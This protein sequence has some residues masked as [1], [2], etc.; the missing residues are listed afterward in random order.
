MNMKL[1]HNLASLF[2]IPQSWRNWI[3]AHWKKWT[4]WKP[5]WYRLAKAWGLCN[6]NRDVKI[7]VSLTSYPGRIG[8]VHETI[9]TLLT[10][11]SK[12]DRVVLW[13]AESQF[14]NREKDLPR[15]LR[16]LEQYG[17]TIKWCA[18]L[19]SYKKL[20]PSLKEYPKDLIITA[21]DDQ[22][23][24]PVMIERLLESYAKNLKCIHTILSMK[25]IYSGCESFTPYN[26]WKYDD[27]FA[28]SFDNLL[29]G[30][31]GALYPPN[32]LDKEVFNED[33]FQ[34]IAPTVDDIWFWAMATKK[35]TRVCHVKGG[36][37]DMLVQN[38]RASMTDAL[39]NTNIDSGSGNDAQL[40]AIVKRYPELLK[41]FAP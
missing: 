5:K 29:M 39:W 17:L 37:E 20:L 11:T 34:T 40:A 15:C 4:H 21:D 26:T 7:T 41:R 18:D 28:D 22:L 36:T 2:L 27:G 25:M 30:G 9:N 35:G 8:T 3:V 23:Y 1:L 32:A 16:T 19:K 24:A 33:V 31:S 14:P 13:L 38:P 10:Q 6:E 12:P